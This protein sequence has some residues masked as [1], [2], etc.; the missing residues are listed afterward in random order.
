MAFDGAVIYQVAGDLGFENL[1]RVARRAG[2]M[3][4]L[5]VTAYY[6]GRRA[7]H[8]VARVIEY[9]LGEVEMLLVYEGFNRH[10]PLRLSVPKDRLEKLVR[11]LRQAKFDT[12]SD[13]DGLSFSDRSLWLIQRAAGTY[14]HSVIVAPDKPQLPWS[15]IVN[16][17]DDYLPGAI[18]EVPLR[19]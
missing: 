15:S 1:N 17:I 2:V 11:A 7:H 10:K 18:R 13:Q 19:N 8:S 9:Q 5:Q 6:F 12:L 14:S 16:A 4:V 3:S